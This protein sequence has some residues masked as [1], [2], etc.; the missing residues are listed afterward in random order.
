M[1]TKDFRLRRARDISRVYGRGRFIG[2][3][4]LTA[5]YLSNGYDYSRAVVVVGKKVSKKAT[6]RNRIR[7]R[8]AAILADKWQTV[9]P[10][11]DIVITVRDDVSDTAPASLSAF[12]DQLLKK[13]P[14]S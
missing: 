10:G 13:I 6:V 9:G 12:I 11:Y 4:P 3:G 1:L 8:I 2:A 14:K 7:R 5:K